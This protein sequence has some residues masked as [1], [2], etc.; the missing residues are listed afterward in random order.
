M[1]LFP[2]QDIMTYI[3]KL[4][5]R[6]IFHLFLYIMLIL[7][8]PIGIAY[9]FIRLAIG[10]ALLLLAALGVAYLLYNKQIRGKEA[11]RKPFILNS[12]R[13]MHFE[14]ICEALENLTGKE[15]RFSLSENLRFLRIEKE[16]KFRIILYKTLNF[17]K[18]NFDASKKRINKKA[19][20]LFNISQWSSRLEASKM[21]RLNIIYADA[22]NEELIDLI[23]Q[24]ANCN[25]SR[26]EGV[27]NIA[28]VD[29]QILVPPIYGYFYL[30]HVKRYNA[31]VKFIDQNITSS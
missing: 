29:N 31:V 28:I 9:L 30:S 7:T 20:Q 12:G 8:I 25:L 13:E 19:N 1:E 15:N 2:M 21:M 27:M 26:S 23:S 24:N 18:S 3:K 6:E 17:G 10:L 4:Q 11:I 14:E 22:L 5:R 16:F